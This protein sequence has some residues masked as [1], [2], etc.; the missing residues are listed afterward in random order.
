MYVMYVYGVPVLVL[1]VVVVVLV[2][3]LKQPR[4]SGSTAQRPVPF[5]DSF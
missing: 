2:L 1:V 5:L 4:R 3:V